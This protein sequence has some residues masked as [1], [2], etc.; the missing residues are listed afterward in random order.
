MPYK[1]LPLQMI[2]MEERFK[3]EV[4]GNCAKCFRKAKEDP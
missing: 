4:V 2:E 3:K 1:D